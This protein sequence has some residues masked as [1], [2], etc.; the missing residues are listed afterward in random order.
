MMSCN[1]YSEVGDY[2]SHYM[3]ETGHNKPS[4]YPSY[5][6]FIA[7]PLSESNYPTGRYAPSAA[8]S[9]GNE[10]YRQ[11]MYI[12]SDHLPLPPPA[13]ADRGVVMYAPSDHLP[14]PPP[15]AADRGMVMYAPSDHLP[16][17]PPATA[18][19]GMVMYAPSD[20][21][22]PPAATAV[23]VEHEDD[24]LLQACTE[25]LVKIGYNVKSLHAGV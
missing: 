10:V 13:T 15:A 9:I 23:S 2:S 21:A 1:R 20:N 19:R 6:G 22:L 24:E 18:D 4:F 7:I 5:D 12:P 25:A 14:L 3:Q 17:P 8:L 11:S 16:L